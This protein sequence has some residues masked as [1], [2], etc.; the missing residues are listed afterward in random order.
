MARAFTRLAT[1]QAV[2]SST[3]QAM[4]SS[5]LSIISPIPSEPYSPYDVEIT[6]VTRLV[7][8]GEATRRTVFTQEGGTYKT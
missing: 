7:G 8:Q 1:Y 5:L 2:K 6:P 4:N 3:S